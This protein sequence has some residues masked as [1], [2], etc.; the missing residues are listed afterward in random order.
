M[1]FTNSCILLPTDYIRGSARYDARTP[2]ISSASASSHP[3]SLDEETL[4]LLN[5][6]NKFIAR[7]HLT[8][9]DYVGKGHFGCVYKAKLY[10]PNREETD[11]VA[12]KTLQTTGQFQKCH[13]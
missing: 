8:L 3:F 9:G 4:A 5:G 2:L 13:V 10:H 12:V 11:E 7:E 1:S 6:D